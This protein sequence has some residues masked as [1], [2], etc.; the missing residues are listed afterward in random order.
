MTGNGGL[1]LFTKWAPS[2]WLGRRLGGLITAI[3]SS[4]TTLL[5]SRN[6]T[7]G[8][9]QLQI[10]VHSVQ[11]RLCQ[12]VQVVSF[13]KWRYSLWISSFGA[14][15][16]R[17]RHVSI[18]ALT[19]QIAACTYSN[20]TTTCVP[21]T[22]SKFGAKTVITWYPSSTQTAELDPSSV[23]STQTAELPFFYSACWANLPLLSLLSY[24][25]STQPAELTFLYSDCWATLPLLTLLSYPSSTYAAELP[26]STHTAELPSSTHTAELPFLY[27][28]CW[29]TFLYSHCWAT[30]PLHT[31]LAAT[32]D[33]DK[34]HALLSAID[35]AG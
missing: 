32:C 14:L 18:N 17:R 12:L 3:V 35:H 10:F 2:V 25:S 16:S 1:H 22:A 7:I 19:N 24:P 30:L 5:A 9:V 33:T 29:A 15:F 11:Q 26:S 4:Q 13:K 34:K 8:C 28:H 20:A 6:V 23:S 21:P 27:S 31:L